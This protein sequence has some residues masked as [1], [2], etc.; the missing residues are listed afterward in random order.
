MEAIFYETLD[1]VQRH[2]PE[3]DVAFIERWYRHRRPVNNS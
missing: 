3:I 2:V 1:L